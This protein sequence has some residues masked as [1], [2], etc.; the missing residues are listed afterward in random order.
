VR[1]TGHRIVVYTM[2]DCPICDLIKTNVR[3]TE[4]R[5]IED[6]A[7]GKIHDREAMAQLQ[8]QDQQAPVVIVDGFAVTLDAL[9]RMEALHV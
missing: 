5:S 6:L 3:V 7:S 2:P 4:E 9:M 1:N 8:L